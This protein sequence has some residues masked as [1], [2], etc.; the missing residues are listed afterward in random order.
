MLLVPFHSLKRG[1][2]DLV[3]GSIVIRGGKVPADLVK[4]LS[5]PRRDRQIVV[6][7]VSI[8]VL[9]TVAGPFSVD[10]MPSRFQPMLKVAKGMQEMGIQNPGVVDLD[11]R[12]SERHH[13][14]AFV[15]TGYLPTNADGSASCRARR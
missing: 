6:A 13:L 10:G 3:T 11:R 7:G 8:A 9:A 1:L 4:R 14:A 5:N 2:H 15:A 12:G